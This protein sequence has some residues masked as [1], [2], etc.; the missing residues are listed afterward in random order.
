MLLSN[1]SNLLKNDIIKSLLG[2][3]YMNAARVGPSPL[4]IPI[5]Q[6]TIIKFMSDRHPK[7]YN[8]HIFDKGS[9]NWREIFH[10]SLCKLSNQVIS[11]LGRRQ[12][13]L[14]PDIHIIQIFNDV[15]Y[16]SENGEY[17]AVPDNPCIK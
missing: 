15:A 13:K 7:T 8:E 12:T 16:T 6:Y 5:Y 11:D 2:R 10:S 1:L 3:G 9:I 4:L 14:R 17:L